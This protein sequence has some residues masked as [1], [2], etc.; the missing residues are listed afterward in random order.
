MSNRQ[1]LSAIENALICWFNP[2]LNE[3]NKQSP[4]KTTQEGF[5]YRLR[6]SAGL[7]QVELANTIGVTDQTISNWER[8]IHI[9]KLTPR[10]MANLCKA[11]NRTIEEIADLLEP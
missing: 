3:T 6:I 1:L 4:E 9:P 7:S 8:G 2:V 5:F 11:M 10:Q